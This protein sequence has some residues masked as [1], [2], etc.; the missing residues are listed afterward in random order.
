MNDHYLANSD[1]YDKAMVD[2]GT[3]FSYFP[4]ALMNNIRTHFDWF[5]NA[6]IKNCDGQFQL[7]NTVQICFDYSVEKNPDLKAYFASYPMLR[8]ALPNHSTARTESAEQS[9]QWFFNWYPS[10]YLYRAKE[11]QYCVA[12]ETQSGHR[13]MFGGTL[14]R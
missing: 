3:T 2:T 7:K 1:A 13:I 11:N 12:A 14:L 6:D 9:N 4:T 8:F 5:C 10:E